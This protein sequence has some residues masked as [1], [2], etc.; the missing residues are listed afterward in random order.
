MDVMLESISIP[1]S[2]V[3]EFAPKIRVFKINADKV[4]EVIGKG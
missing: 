3:K 2:Q 4:R 1:R